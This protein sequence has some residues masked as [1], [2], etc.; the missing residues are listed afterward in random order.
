V[1]EVAISNVR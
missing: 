1:C